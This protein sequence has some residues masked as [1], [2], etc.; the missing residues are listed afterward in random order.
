[1]DSDTDQNVCTDSRDTKR[2]TKF[3]TQEHGEKRRDKVVV[4]FQQPTD[5]EGE[6]VEMASEEARG[7]QLGG[8]APV[9]NKKIRPRADGPG[10]VIFIPDTTVFH[11]KLSIDDSDVHRL[12]QVIS[13][14]RKAKGALEGRVRR[15]HEAIVDFVTEETKTLLAGKISEGLVP[16]VV[17]HLTAAGQIAAWALC[18]RTG[19]ILCSAENGSRKLPLVGREV[20]SLIYSLEDTK[21]CQEIED[22]VR[23]LLAA[24]LSQTFK[25]VEFPTHYLEL[26]GIS[27]QNPTT[28]NAEVGGGDEVPAAGE[29]PYLGEYVQAIYVLI[30][31]YDHDL[32]QFCIEHGLSCITIPGGRKKNHQRAGAVVST[33]GNGRP[34]RH[35]VNVVWERCWAK[36]GKGKNRCQAQKDAT[37]WLLKQLRREFRENHLK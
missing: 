8:G 12:I 3:Q 25:E 37:K 36:K 16:E 17:K 7:S 1:M 10:K 6:D 26:L 14:I 5:S 23:C 13:P 15:G 4:H 28:D 22:G 18:F 34:V 29:T 33:I 32:T 31:K 35:R 21:V 27:Q 11:F 20:L 24:A 19:A 2:D 30:Q 9:P